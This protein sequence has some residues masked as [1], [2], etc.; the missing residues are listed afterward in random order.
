[1]LQA[2]SHT[3][4]RSLIQTCLLYNGASRSISWNQGSLLLSWL[5]A[6]ERII[7]V[8][9]FRL[10]CLELYGASGSLRNIWAR[11]RLDSVLCE[12]C[13]RYPA[14]VQSAT[15]IKTLHAAKRMSATPQF[16]TAPLSATITTPTT[17]S[18]IYCL[19]SMIFS[20]HKVFEALLCLVYFLFGRSRLHDVEVGMDT[21]NVHIPGFKV[22]E[23]KADAVP[24]YPWSV[25]GVPALALASMTM[26]AVM[27]PGAVK[28][29][30]PPSIPA[31][32][33]TSPTVGEKI[34]VNIDGKE[35]DVTPRAKEIDVKR[36][37]L[38]QLTNGDTRVHGKVPTRKSLRK[39]KENVRAHPTA[40]CHPRLY[41][42]PPRLQH[43]RIT[44]LSA[45]APVAVAPVPEIPLYVVPDFIPVPP[46]TKPGSSQW[47]LEK[48][49]RLDE[50]RAFSDKVQD[51]RRLS[52]FLLAPAP[53]SVASVPANT[54]GVVPDLIPASHVVKPGS[55][56]WDLE[57]TRRLDEARAFSDKVR[58]RRRCSLPPVLPSSPTA[59]SPTTRHDSAPARLSI[60]ERLQRAVAA[61]TP[62]VS[63]APLWGDV[64]PTFVLDDEDDATE[65][66]APPPARGER[67]ARSIPTSSS[68]SAL[69]SGASSSESLTA[70]LDAL[71]AELH[72]P[73]W[74]ALLARD[75]GSNGDRD[76]GHWSEVVSLEDYA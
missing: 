69:S 2:S 50:A 12:T 60:E 52:A 75:T 68:S 48:T 38:R 31:I 14:N 40:P 43:T 36:A 18:F 74:F 4:L 39:A 5:W 24:L 25:E 64:N 57:K 6:T 46:V 67:P 56:Q 10:R 73:T 27:V 65:T 63:V 21:P 15:T 42:A 11:A 32:I 23:I 13:V 29:A 1:M 58:D 55:S 72:S 22:V 62:A 8:L 33:F 53:V 54:V 19:Y 17:H 3:I 34:D 44:V 26:S 47:D 61:A 49:R 9:T 28:P 70:V 71:E 45:P 41:Q 35:L 7:Q 20:L 37:P 51:H 76:S 30:I 16:S 59:T 66:W